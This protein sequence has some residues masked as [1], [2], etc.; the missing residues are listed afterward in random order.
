MNQLTPEERAILEDLVAGELGLDS[1]SA[2]ELFMKH[3]DLREQV[4]DLL[5][6]VSLLDDLQRLEGE[7]VA[8][9]EAGGGADSPKG[10]VS[11]AATLHPQIRHTRRPRILRRW[12]AAA[13]VLIA[14]TIVIFSEREPELPRI[15]GGAEWNLQPSGT[16][17]TLEQFE[18][19]YPGV[20]QRFVVELTVG[21]D[22][23]Q[24]FETDRSPWTPPTDLIP[25]LRGSEIYWK[26]E[27]YG[28]SPQP[29]DARGSVF[30]WSD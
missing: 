20:A 3:P 1:P 14:A 17:E 13:A 19:E 8:E 18:W 6:T 30:I 4:T 27:A 15:L 28:V 24:R 23:P 29:L 10:T 21:D 7:V 25:Q 9:A 11:V 22:A 16:I 12:A 26:V 2:Q 5:G